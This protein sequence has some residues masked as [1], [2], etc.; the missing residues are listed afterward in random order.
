MSSILYYSNHCQHSAKLL[1]TLSKCK[2]ILKDMHFICIDN[3]EKS[4]DGKTFIILD[5][6]QKI[7]MP[8]NVTR[9][10]GL[11]LLTQGYNVLYGD[12]ITAHLKP[13]E[14]VAVT[15]AT[16]NNMEPLTDEGPMAFGGLSGAVASDSFSYYDQSDKDL[17]T[18]GN[19]GTRQMHNYNNYG[20]NDMGLIAPP[21]EDPNL[22][23][24]AN[25]VPAS[26]SIESLQKQRMSELGEFTSNKR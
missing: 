7:I 15:E 10:P 17:G 20:D 21:D 3:R 2:S 1:E 13:R 8:S 18:A 24:N 14:D 22:Q 6:G 5:N 12:D 16:F 19:G 11:L 23:K 4:N 26:V 25:K 9:V